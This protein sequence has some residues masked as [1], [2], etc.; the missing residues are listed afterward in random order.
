MYGVDVA[1]QVCESIRTYVALLLRWNAKIPLTSVV[2]PGEIL[3][4]HFGE[5]LFA[6]SVVAIRRSR[7]ADVGSGAGFPGLAL[8]VALPDSKVVLIESNRKKAWFLSEVSRTLALD[9]VEVLAKRMEEIP[10]EMV[11]F[12]FITARAIGQHKRLL[13]W[14]KSKLCVGGKIVLWVG[15]SDAQSIASTSDWAWQ[16]P[17]HIPGSR[18]RYLLVGSPEP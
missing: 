11:D 9:G 18:R 5:S 10:R 12:G 15:E 1:P 14:A 16:D 17:L 7:I 13:K 8:R 2:D 6:A 3:R 4:F